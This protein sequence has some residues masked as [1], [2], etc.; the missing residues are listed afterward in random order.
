MNI[1]YDNGVEIFKQLNVQP[2]VY[3]SSQYFEEHVILY[4]TYFRLSYTQVQFKLHN[5]EINSLK[6]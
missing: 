3:E 5:Q 1:N 4:N 6:F 2:I